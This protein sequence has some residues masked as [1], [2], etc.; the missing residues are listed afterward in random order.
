[1]PDMDTLDDASR[2]QLQLV[3]LVSQGYVGHSG[4]EQA[5]GYLDTLEVC[6]PNTLI[7]EHPDHDLRSM[8]RLLCTLVGEQH[9]DSWLAEVL[10][11]MIGNPD[12]TLDIAREVVEGAEAGET[13]GW[14][15]RRVAQLLRAGYGTP[16]ASRQAGVHRN[17]VSK[18]SLFID[19]AGAQ[20][21]LLRNAAV[22]VAARGGGTEDMMAE[23][24][25]CRK[26]AQRHLRRIREAIA[27]MRE[28]EVEAACA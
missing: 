18:V 20:W 26:V 12:L 8:M 23:A 2:A 16:E 3:S 10:V 5:V 14:K 15:L 22:R 6:D 9:D 19:S 1:M 21:E 13:P 27:S 4:L 17:I 24:G 11:A 25:C 7:G 28:D